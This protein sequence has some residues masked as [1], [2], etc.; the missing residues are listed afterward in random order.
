MNIQTQ[1]PEIIYLTDPLV[2]DGKPTVRLLAEV[3]RA[4]V[5]PQHG[6]VQE[7]CFVDV[8]LPKSRNLYGPR[9]KALI[10]DRLG[11]DYLLLRWTEKAIH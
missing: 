7:F 4:N 3:T 9:L 8:V 1:S 6:L 11:A 5:H 2:G 10:N